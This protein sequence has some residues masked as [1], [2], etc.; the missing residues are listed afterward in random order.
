MRKVAGVVVVVVLLVLVVAPAGVGLMV[1][2]NY[3][4]LW[5]AALEDQPGYDA[6]VAEYERGWFSSSARVEIAVSEPAMAE[7]LSESDWGKADEQDGTVRL[8]LHERIHHGPLALGAPAPFS[9]RLRP[10]A[11]VVHTHLDQTLPLDGVD[12]SGITMTTRLGL[13]GQLHA[14]LRI[15]PMEHEFDDG[16]SLALEHRMTLDIRTDQAL[17]RL[18]SELR[19]DSL[20][21]RGDGGE[22]VSLESIRAQTDQRRGTGGLWLGE[23]DFRAGLIGMAFPMGAPLEVRDLRW[24][25]Q[26]SEADALLEQQHQIR[27]KSVKSGALTAQPV[28][29][30]MSFYNLDIRSITTLQERLAELPPPHP[31]APADDYASELLDEVR[32]TLRRMARHEP[33]LRL[34]TLS[35]GLEDGTLEGNGKLEVI[36]ADDATFDHHLDRG[37]LIRLLQADGRLAASREMVRQTLIRTMGE[38]ISHPDMKSELEDMADMQIDQA[39]AEGLLVENADNLEMRLRLEQGVFHLNQREIYR[40]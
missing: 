34:D 31:E 35:I 25:S 18:Q 19:G 39:I 30:D 4:Q 12:I 32:D 37:T 7:F 17:Q 27:A 3:R 29:L 1:E 23:T 6:S 28:R 20:Y 9:Q 38:G 26:A 33:G 13:G 16:S 10:G 36:A 2:N 8:S 21:I 40:F 5:Q 15:E 24:Q 22:S 11:G 14:H